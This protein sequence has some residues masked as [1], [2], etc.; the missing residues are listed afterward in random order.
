MGCHWGWGYPCVVLRE[1]R[2]AMPCVVAPPAWRVAAHGSTCAVCPVSVSVDVSLSVPVSVSVSVSVAVVGAGAGDTLRVVPVGFM[3]NG[4]GFSSGRL[5][6]DSKNDEVW[7]LLGNYGQGDPLLYVQ[8]RGNLTSASYVGL[9][10]CP[11]FPGSQSLQVR[12]PP[13]RTH[14]RPHT[15]THASTRTLSVHAHAHALS[16][17]AHRGDGDARWR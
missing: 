11:G 1:P 10:G 7:E 2:H 8:A 12:A 14:T 6:Y 5:A 9:Q 17:S 15:T 3:S 4:L 16:H 13:C